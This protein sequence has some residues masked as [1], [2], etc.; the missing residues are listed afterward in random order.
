MIICTKGNDFP[1]LFRSC[2]VSISAVRMRRTA[3]CQGRKQRR[4]VGVPDLNTTERLRTEEQTISICF[5]SV[6]D[7]LSSIISEMLMNF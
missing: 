4:W 5:V 3:K 1:S 6:V 2:V 7:V